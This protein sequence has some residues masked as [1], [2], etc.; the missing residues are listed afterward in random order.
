MLTARINVVYH[1]KN[2][3]KTAV[4]CIFLFYRRLALT[5][6]QTG[7]PYKQGESIKMPLLAKTFETIADDPHAMYNGSLADDVV[8]D[9]QEAGNTSP[10]NFL[11][12]FLYL[13]IQ[14]CILVFLFCRWNYYYARLTTLRG[15]YQR[16]PGD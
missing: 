8:A 6:P 7:R 15:S 12:V 4:I 9:I 5:N 16:A 13:H 1:Y 2:D 3:R 11:F 14:T 10:V